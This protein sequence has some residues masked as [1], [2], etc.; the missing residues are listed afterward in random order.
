MLQTNEEITRQLR[1]DTRFGDA[2]RKKYNVTLD[3]TDDQ[4]KEKI[5]LFNNNP[6]DSQ[7]YLVLEGID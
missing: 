3:M 4:I 1:A 2:V 5:D 6:L 7:G